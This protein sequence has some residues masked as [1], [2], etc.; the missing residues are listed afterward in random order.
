MRTHYLSV[1]GM[2]SGAC[3]SKV[4]EALSVLRGVGHVR[5]SL[6]HGAVTI[7]CNERHVSLG[8]ITSA[9]EEAG[10]GIDSTGPVHTHRA[11]PPFNAPSLE[12]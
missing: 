6:T 11:P 4:A 8:E 12:P 1:T 9:I 2:T 5:V 3:R 7:H 10:Y